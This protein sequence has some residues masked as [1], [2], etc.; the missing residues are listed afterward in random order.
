MKYH[1]TLILNKLCVFCFSDKDLECLVP[2]F[3]RSKSSLKV[4]GVLW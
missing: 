2:L 3:L 1:K 4:S